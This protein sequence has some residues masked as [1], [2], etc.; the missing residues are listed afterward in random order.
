MNKIAIYIS[1]RHRGTEEQHEQRV[2]KIW[3]LAQK[4]FQSKYQCNLVKLTPKDVFDVNNQL[5]TNQ[6]FNDVDEEC[7]G[8]M[9]VEENENI[10]NLYPS[11]N[12]NLAR[13]YNIGHIFAV[14]F[15][16][17]HITKLQDINLVLS[18]HTYGETKPRRI[19]FDES[20]PEQYANILLGDSE[21][22]ENDYKNPYVNSSFLEACEDLDNAIWESNCN[23]HC[24]T[25]DPEIQI[26]SVEENSTLLA[27][28]T[29]TEIKQ[30]LTKVME[31][32]VNKGID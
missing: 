32:L 26:T 11:I 30:L 31:L 8:L 3:E 9:F 20:D 2:N 1:L 13:E 16:Q 25:Q 10:D 24:A 7:F 22:F 6:H 17:L 27:V 28:D 4:M 19:L 18:V 23:N 29:K 15:D 21:D 14:R 5:K 12:L